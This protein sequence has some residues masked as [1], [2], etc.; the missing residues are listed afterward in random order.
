MV[1]IKY[2]TSK[3]FPKLLF[4]GLLENQFLNFRFSTT[5]ICYLSSLNML[6]DTATLYPNEEVSSSSSLFLLLHKFC[7][8]QPMAVIT[9]KAII[10]DNI[11][12]ITNKV[13]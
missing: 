6:L 8:P 7:I 11:Q 12:K 13:E 3:C 2:I 1:F 5:F 9:S 10:P 4:V